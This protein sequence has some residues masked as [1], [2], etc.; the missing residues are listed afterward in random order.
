MFGAICGDVIG[1]PYEFGKMKDYDFELFEDQS[2]LTDDSFMTAAVARAIMTG[3]LDDLDRR[4]AEQYRIFYKSHPDAGYGGMFSRWAK[5]GDPGYLKSWGNGSAMRVSP[6]GW[7]FDT[8]EDVIEAATKTALPTHGSPEGIRGA[9]AIAICVFLARKGVSKDDIKKKIET[10]YYYDV[11]EPI[12]STRK[13]YKFD[14]S[15][16]MS[17][18][19]AIRAFLE[20]EDFEDAVRLAVSVGGDSDTIGA[21]VGAI[22]EAAYGVPSDI[23]FNVLSRFTDDVSAV[24]AEFCKA[25]GRDMPIKIF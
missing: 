24:Y 9:R 22:A 15:C 21:M 13:W 6:A 19:V 5:S 7:L 1:S 11:D 25:V 3:G 20:S 4:C 8:E 23:S 18:P 12:A 2:R 14:V 10:D 16:Q 17:V